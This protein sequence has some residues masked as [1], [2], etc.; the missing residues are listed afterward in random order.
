MLNTT[1]KC[2]RS[3]GF[4]TTAMR[5]RVLTTERRGATL[6]GARRGGGHDR[7]DQGDTDEEEQGD[8]EKKEGHDEQ[9]KAT[10]SKG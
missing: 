4:G 10:M 8:D 7:E 2:C 6:N 1:I 3:P 5:R 9:G